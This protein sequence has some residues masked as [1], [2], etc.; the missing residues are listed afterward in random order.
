VT[1]AGAFRQEL[2]EPVGGRVLLTGAT[3]YVG[4]RLLTALVAAKRTVRCLARR[5]DALQHRVGPHVAVVP[6]DLQDRATLDAALAGC[7]AAYYLVHSMGAEAGFEEADRRAATNFAGAARAAGVRRVVYLGGLGAGDALSPHLSSRQEVGR[8]L[9]ESGIPTLEFRASIVIGSGSLSFEMIRALVERLPVM[10]TPSWVRTRSQPIAIEDLIAY[11]LAGLDADLPASRVFEI[12]GADIASYEALMHEYARQRGLRRLILRVPV[13]S[14]KLSSLWLGLVTP[15]YARVGRK[16]I[17]SLRNPTVVTDDSARRVFGV[18]P[19]GYRDAIARALAHED[20][21]FAETR[22]SDALSAGGLPRAW[23]GVRFGSRLVDTRAVHVD[24]PPRVGFEAIER[25]GG[26]TGWYA[27]DA[28]W[29]LR[30]FLDLL[31]G[32][33]GR[34]RGRRDPRH[35]V[36]GDPVDFWRVEAVE[37]GCL[38]R[39]AAEMRLPGRAWLVFEVT[40]DGPGAVIRQT[41]LFDPAGLLGRVYWYALYPVHALVFG[42]MLRAI[43]RRVRTPRGR[44]APPRRRPGAEAP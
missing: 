38:L 13:L 40:P 37:P 29:Q 39:L 1:A 21:E 33:V 30:G 27:F 15:L 7:E 19:R 5:P 26:A 32:G 2:A 16:L 6:G 23:A 34:R 24:A 18:R 14:P 4:G 9:A 31:V 44:A 36:V 11:L 41:A 10:T 43:A 8:I 20:R 35:L 17:D 12:G 22:W 25:L 42:G 28:L 3:G